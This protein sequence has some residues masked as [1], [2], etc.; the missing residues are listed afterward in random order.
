MLSPNCFK[1]WL[2]VACLWLPACSLI[3]LNQ[4]NSGIA[5]QD[6]PDLE[7]SSEQFPADPAGAVGP[8]VG[9]TPD[10]APADCLS[11]E[12][13][14]MAQGIADSFEMPFEQVIDWHCAGHA[15]EDILL[16]LH[17]G[18]DLKIPPADLLARLDQGQTWEQIWKDVGWLK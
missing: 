14:T 4:S 10:A 17:T 18:D 15:F 5:G 1:I 9:I 8:L 7:N 13:Q 6:Q 3:H 2:L 16:A 12:A 11:P